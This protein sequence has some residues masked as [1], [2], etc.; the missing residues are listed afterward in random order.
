M[1]V[2][3][4]QRL[5]RDKPKAR[6]WTLSPTFQ[7]KPMFTNEYLFMLHITLR[8][9]PVAVVTPYLIYSRRKS[10]SRNSWEFRRYPDLTDEDSKPVPAKDDP[11]MG[12]SAPLYKGD[13][14]YIEPRSRKV[15][16][17]ETVANYIQRKIHPDKTYIL[18]SVT[19]ETTSGAHQTFLL[20]DRVRKEFIYFDPMNFGSILMEGDE[21]YRSVQAMMKQIERDVRVLIEETFLWDRKEF[22]QYTI[23]FLHQTMIEC[24][25]FLEGPRMKVAPHASAGY[26]QPLSFY[27]MDALITYRDILLQRKPSGIC[28][29]HFIKHFICHPRFDPN[30]LSDRQY[31]QFLG[32]HT[33]ELL[34]VDSPEYIFAT[35][36]DY[37]KALITD[38]D[39]ECSER[40]QPW[41]I[42]NEYCKEVM[43]DFRNRRCE[44]L[45][46][47]LKN[48]TYAGI[49]RDEGYFGWVE[50][51]EIYSVIW[52]CR[53]FSSHTS[54]LNKRQTR[55]LYKDLYRSVIQ[56]NDWD[57]F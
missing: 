3:K 53:Q 47:G 10:N 44:V 14:L 4:E 19:Q 23:R 36:H 1:N 37:L 55:E 13:P 29:D 43:V 56:F 17:K 15:A 42:F 35:H 27:I 20:I 41:L 8:H 39:K 57:E 33:D 34:A 9:R 24:Q 48:S 38:F 22:G 5:P 51:P 54:D 40:P 6:P 7:F 25:L 52:N 50:Q 21:I 18:F 2:L 45:Y 26:C 12:N 28:L 32:G 11:R 49:S 30:A 16:N 31:L 46:P